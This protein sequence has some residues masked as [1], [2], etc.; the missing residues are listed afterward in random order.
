[1]E[2]YMLYPFVSTFDVFDFYVSI[3]KSLFNL[4][5]VDLCVFVLFD[6][7]SN[8]VSNMRV[9]GIFLGTGFYHFKLIYTNLLCTRSLYIHSI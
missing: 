5:R 1:M 3:K 9:T 4:I 8:E 2:K 7:H 6:G